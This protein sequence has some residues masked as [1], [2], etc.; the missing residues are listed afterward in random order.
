MTR[1]YSGFSVNPVEYAERIR[2]P[3][4][5]MQGDSDPY[6]KLQESQDVFDHLAAPKRMVIF[7]NAG[8]ESYLCRDAERWRRS[9]AEFLAK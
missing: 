4:L 6:V 2:C 9:I 8:H 5:L 3:V 1:G 7:E